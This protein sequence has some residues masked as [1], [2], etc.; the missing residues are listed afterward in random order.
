MFPVS[1][2]TRELQLNWMTEKV[3]VQNNVLN[4]LDL[5][6]LQNKHPVSVAKSLRMPQF[7]LEKVT[8]KERYLTDMEFEVAFITQSN[9]ARPPYTCS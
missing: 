6:F 7:E 5:N 9:L 1:K 8:A 2:T 4:F 3:E